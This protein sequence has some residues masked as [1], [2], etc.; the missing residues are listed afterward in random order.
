M[1]IKP[2]FSP[3][4]AIAIV[5]AALLIFGILFN[6]LIDWA[7]RKRILDGYTAY[8]VALG[9]LVTLGGVAFLNW[10]AAL[11]VLGAFIASGL[12]MLVG[13]TWRFM[14]ARG[15]EKEY[16]RQAARMAQYCERSER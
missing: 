4:L 16:E 2:E 10:Q 12:P 3:I 9:V 8:A 13:S 14:E 1:L 15:K 5:Y 11:L 7:E 6:T